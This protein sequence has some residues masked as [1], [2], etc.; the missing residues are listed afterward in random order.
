MKNRRIIFQYDFVRD[1]TRQK[2][3]QETTALREILSVAAHWSTILS[4]Q[5]RQCI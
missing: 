4:I 3:D 2:S 1:I 5:L